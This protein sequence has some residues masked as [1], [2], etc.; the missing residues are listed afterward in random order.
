MYKRQVLESVIRSS[1]AAFLA[2]SAALAAGFRPGCGITGWLCAVCI[3][4]LYIITFSWISVYFGIIANG[5]EGAGAFSV[6]ALVLPYLSSGF[7]PVETMPAVL[8][9]FSK[10]QPMTPVIESIRALLLGQPLPVSTLLAAVIWC[11]ALLILFY[12][13]SVRAFRK[14][15]TL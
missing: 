6:I 9:I 14:K 13:L 8:R 1:I 5:P 7:V 15:I 12:L 4:L 3:L 11:L 2:V 10:Y